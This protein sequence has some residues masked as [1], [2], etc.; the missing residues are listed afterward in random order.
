MRHQFVFSVSLAD[1]GG[2]HTV[3]RRC[4]LQLNLHERRNCRT[5]QLDGIS[6][7]NQ[8]EEQNPPTKVAELKI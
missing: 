4:G 3:A 6:P 1:C 7:F 8:D 5:V 2:D